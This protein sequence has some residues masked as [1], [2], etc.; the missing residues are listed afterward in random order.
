MTRYELINTLKEEILEIPIKR[1]I[2]SRISEY[3]YGKYLCP[4]HDDHTPNNFHIFEQS[5]SY[6]CFACGE[7]GNAI[8]FI[9]HY[10]NLTYAEAILKIA[11]EQ[12]LITD[13]DS[14]LKKH[15]SPKHTVSKKQKEICEKADVDILDQVY[16]I[17]M[18][19]N[20][21]IGKPRLSDEHLY[22][23]RNDRNLS[24]ENIEKTGYFT[25]P[26]GFIMKS[27][28]KELMKKN[29]DVDVL[30]QV[31]GFYYDIKK[32]GYV[33][34]K[35]KD[36]TGIGIPILDINGKVVGIQIRTD[37]DGR[38]QWFSSSF[39]NSERVKNFKYGTSPG[40]P[41]AVFYP[42]EIKCKT[43]FITEGHFKAKKICETFSTIAL[44]VQGVNNWREI[45]EIVNELKARY[46]YLDTIMIAF[47]ADMARKETVL[48]PAIKMGM[49]LTG[50]PLE[51]T[52]ERDLQNILHVGNKNKEHNA[53]VYGKEA[54]QIFNFLQTNTLD[55]DIFYCLWDE[56]YGKGIDDVLNMN[57][58]FA[59]KKLDFSTFW[60][61]S[62][63]YLKDLDIKRE[64]IS[65]KDGTEYRKTSVPEYMKLEYFYKDV[66][67]HL[68][69]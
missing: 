49:A 45:P 28:L 26:N 42:E 68:V 50:L 41:V 21:L 57:H 58:K 22:K 24:D 11:Y 37:D 2:D 56:K 33:F 23:L 55:F 46:F 67:A 8:T 27:F 36:T 19:G 62:Y 59:L 5:N 38:Y 30:R 7:N 34:S 10:D 47:D 40:T 66:F 14:V 32:D 44:S 69:H 64:E 4:F 63:Q 20:T 54:K 9:M 39:V 60:M 15:V 31:P 1:I 52:M 12:N 29:L 25:F 3:Q 16:R 53:S 48:Q 6:H 35:L 65:E 51:K 13:I 18:K 17:F 61:A 43:I